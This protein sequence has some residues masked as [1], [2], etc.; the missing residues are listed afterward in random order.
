[1]GLQIIL[2]KCWSVYNIWGLL[3]EKYELEYEETFSP[4]AKM[5]SNRATLSTPAYDGLKM[6]EPMATRCKEYISLRRY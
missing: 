2:K 4:L 5:T 3:P 1:M 6:I